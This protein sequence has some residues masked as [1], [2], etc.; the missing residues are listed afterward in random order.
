MRILGAMEHNENECTTDK[1]TLLTAVMGVEKVSAD[2]LIHD[3]MCRFERS[4]LIHEPEAFASVKYGAI[5]N[6]HRKRHIC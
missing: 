5:D 1:I 3:D 2:L 6:F 4:A